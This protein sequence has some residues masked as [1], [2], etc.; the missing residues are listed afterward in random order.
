[1]LKKI[2]EQKNYDTVGDTI[3]LANNVSVFEYM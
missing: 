3:G 1:M 2:F